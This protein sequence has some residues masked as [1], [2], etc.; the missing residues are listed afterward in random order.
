M[1]RLG[2]KE[3]NLK[4]FVKFI[5]P[6]MKLIGAWPKPTATSTFSKAIKWGLIVSAYFLQ[7]LVFVPG[8]LYLFLKEKNGKKRIHIMIP[9]INGFSQL[10]KYTILLRRTSEFSKIL[11]QL[12]DDW[13]DATED[14]RHIFRMRANIG[15]RMVLTVAITM[16][17]TG[18]FY[19]III[20]LSTGRIVL[21]NNTTMRMLP[22]PVYF[23]FFNEQSTPYYEIIFVLQIMGGFLN[24]TILCSTMGVCLMLCLHLSSLLRILMNKMVELTSQLDTSETA[25]QKK[26]SDIVAYQTKVKEFANSVEE[27]T[28]YLYFFEIF[29]YAIEACI[30][31]YCIIV[32]WEES[33]AASIIVYLMFQGICIFCNYAMCY[34]GQLLIN[35]SENVRRMSIT[36]NWYRFP[37]KKAR[38]L[39]L[40][41][42]MSNYPIKL[43]A[44]KIVDISLATFTDIIKAS[45]GY[46]NVLRKVT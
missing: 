17:T 38:S 2:N 33:N 26:I 39:I 41:I 35:E 8:V 42:I 14:S 25:V 36:L 31:G 1:S 34:I 7:L 24:Y 9:H 32:E 43:T 23:V 11:D 5:Y 40:I 46:L 16:Y 13:V 18:L 12:S 28:P 4:H 37:M 21:P 3:E 19:R 6:P 22:C 10:C 27:I 30:V 29:N 15:H 45:V 20:P 44:G